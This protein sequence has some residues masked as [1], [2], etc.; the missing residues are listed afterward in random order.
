MIG[1]AISYHA[2]LSGEHCL[3]ADQTG[4]GKTLAYL[5]PLIQRLR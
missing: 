1:Q 5:T 4:S 3:V 2:V